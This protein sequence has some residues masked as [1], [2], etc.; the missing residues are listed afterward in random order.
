MRH[1][2]Q[3]EKKGMEKPNDSLDT[4]IQTLIKLKAD[5]R[6]SSNSWVRR[7]VPKKMRKLFELLQVK[8]P[9]RFL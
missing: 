7:D 8:E 2:G 1:Y 6:L 5:K 4:V 3:S 9:P